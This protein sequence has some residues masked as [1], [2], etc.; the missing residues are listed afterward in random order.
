MLVAISRFADV[1]AEFETQAR[2]VAE[3]WRSRPGCV[4]VELVQNLDQ[5][6]LWAL[7]SRWASVGDYRRSFNG[8]EAKM[9]LTPVLSRA[10]DE[11]SAYLDPSE[12]GPNLPRVG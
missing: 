8:Y 4:S 9:V 1:G 10:V 2:T 3:F 7:V 5:P 11:P 12:L 6:S